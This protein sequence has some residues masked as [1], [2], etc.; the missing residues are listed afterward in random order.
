MSLRRAIALAAFGLA[1]GACEKAGSGVAGASSSEPG[2]ASVASSPASNDSTAANTAAPVGSAPAPATSDVAALRHSYGAADMRFD[3][4]VKVEDGVVHGRKCTAVFSI[5]GPYVAVPAHSQVQVSFKIEAPSNVSVF[6]D[7]V[8][9]LGHRDH[10]S[11][12]DQPV[13]AKERRSVGYRV[14]FFEDATALEARIGV[15]GDG[16]VDFDI[17]DLVVDVH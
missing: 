5:F 11:I 9:D 4:C 13:A 8:S 12:L 16:P 2:A 7:V 15:R 14:S 17:S 3:G 6:S 1:L 10:A